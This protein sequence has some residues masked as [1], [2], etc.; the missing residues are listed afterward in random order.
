V[1]E[2][3]REKERRRGERERERERDVGWESR[4]MEEITEAVYL[5]CSL[6][7]VGERVNR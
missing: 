2:R 5:Y 3:E 6:R 7:I 4:N 1:K